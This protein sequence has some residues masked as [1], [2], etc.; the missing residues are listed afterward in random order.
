MRVERLRIKRFRGFSRLEVLPRG[1]VILVGPPGCGR[2][3]AVEALRRVLDPESTRGW[4]SEDFDFHNR[5]T[6]KPIVIE[7]VLGDLGE[8]LEQHFLPRTEA[9]DPESADVIDELSAA[10]SGEDHARV[11][12]LSYLARWLDDEEYAEHVVHYSKGAHPRRGIFDVVARRD[13]ELLP[14]VFASPSGQTLSLAARGAFRRLVDDADGEDL[15][16]ALEAL[17]DALDDGAEGLG[18]S[19]QL[20]EALHRVLHPVRQLLDVGDDPEDAVRFTP[21]GSSLGGLLRSLVP[22]VRTAAGWLP[23]SRLGESTASIV[24][25]AEALASI[26]GAGAVVALDDLGERM[27]SRA[28]QHLALRIA[29]RAGQAWLAVRRTD[30]AEVFEPTDLVRLA[31]GSPGR[32]AQQLQR[33]ATRTERVTL[34]HL[35]RQVL[36]ATDAIAAVIVEG[37]DDQDAIE[38]MSKRL[39]G[40]RRWVL[41]AARAAVIHPGGLGA[42]G[43]AGATGRLAKVASDLGLKTAIVLDGDTSPSEV[44]AARAAAD[45][46]LRLPEGFAIEWALVE[47]IPIA[48]TQRALKT[49]VESYDL[50][51]DVPEEE[52]SL[53]EVRSLAVDVLK[54]KGQ[55]LHA[56]FVR[57]LRNGHEKSLVSRVI[58]IASR[59]AAG[60]EERDF[61]QL[62]ETT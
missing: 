39:T 28:G 25:T 3:D 59:F 32:S 44:D 9:W 41:T 51:V 15:G 10:A 13:R 16:E 61:V 31:T 58:A 62:D 56:Q 45:F 1:H 12:R 19:E 53:A 46:V 33:A 4:L 6:S 42:G 20:R 40:Q 48:G 5:D 18:E 11:L 38:E 47:G 22:E 17:L 55:G 8:E 26:Q 21:G 30:I 29:R 2:S 27:D 14:F 34:R 36:A 23:A 37:Q 52:L 50:D 54:K 24:A 57:E 43:G 7:V 35:G 49:L 60:R